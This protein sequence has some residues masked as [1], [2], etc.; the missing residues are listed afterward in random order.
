MALHSP[1]ENAEP[2]KIKNQQLKIT[3][4]SP[5]ENAEP[6][7]IKNQHIKITTETPISP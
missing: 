7:K 3:Q 6:L 5:K 4:H 1:K 2:L